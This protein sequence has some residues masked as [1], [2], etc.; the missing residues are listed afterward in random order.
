MARAVDLLKSDGVSEIGEHWIQSY[1]HSFFLVFK[2]SRKT[3]QLF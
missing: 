2:V 3:C 1:L